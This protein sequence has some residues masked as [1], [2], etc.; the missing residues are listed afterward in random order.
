MTKSVR[1]IN[2][3]KTEVK[4]KK[5]KENLKSVNKCKLRHH[6]PFPPSHIQR[7]SIGISIS[8]DMSMYMRIYCICTM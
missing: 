6:H 5:A 7:S 1:I 4:K 3:L 2:L 8:I